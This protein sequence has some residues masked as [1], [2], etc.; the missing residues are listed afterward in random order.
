MY[1]CSLVRTAQLPTHAA[2]HQRLQA[3]YVEH[4]PGS[5]VRTAYQPTMHSL[6]ILMLHLVPG[7]YTSH[8]S[9]PRLPAVMV[10]LF[11]LFLFLFPLLC[12]SVTGLRRSD[13][14]PSFLFGAGTSAY[15]VRAVYGSRCRAQQASCKRTRAC[16]LHSL[17]T[18]L[19]SYMPSSFFI[20]TC[21]LT[22]GN[23]IIPVCQKNHQENRKN[24]QK[25]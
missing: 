23:Y 9:R 4:Q 12:S 1:V 22:A 6:Q 5:V 7:R 24:R 3:R 25:N 13:F 19:M 16:S 11:F 8:Q 2:Q 21:E 18:R 17:L 15:Q 10:R 14:P 20:I